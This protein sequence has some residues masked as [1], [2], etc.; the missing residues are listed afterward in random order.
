MHNYSLCLDA[1][2]MGVLGWVGMLLYRRRRNAGHFDR[3]SDRIALTPAYYLSITRCAG[4]THA[5]I[6]LGGF[7]RLSHREG[8]VLFLFRLMPFCFAFAVAYNYHAAKDHG[9]G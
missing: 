1:H 7:D 4:N 5:G 6:L 9:C 8:L 2:P 3:L